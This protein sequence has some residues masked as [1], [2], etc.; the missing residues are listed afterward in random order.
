M[1]SQIDWKLLVAVCAFAFA[2]FG[3][4]WNRRTARKALAYEVSSVP[5]TSV[6]HDFSGRLKVVFDGVPVDSVSVVTIRIKNPGA[7]PIRREDFERPLACILKQAN[8]FLTAE[9]SA[10]QPEALDPQLKQAV[11]EPRLEVEPLLLNPRD[12]FTVFALVRGSAEALTLLARIA[13]I[14]EI[15]NQAIGLPADHARGTAPH[16]VKWIVPAAGAVGLAL[17]INLLAEYVGRLL[18]L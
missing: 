5:L 9:V 14:S 16:I 18:V 8:S 13:G 1:L 2:I 17:I 6:T 4:W 7:T 10:R 11:D 3:F 12:Q 15:E